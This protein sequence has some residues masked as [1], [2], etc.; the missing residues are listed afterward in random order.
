MASNT[1]LYLFASWSNASTAC[2]SDECGPPTLH[3]ACRFLQ[4]DTEVAGGGGGGGGGT[5]VE[6]E[7]VREAE[8][9]CDSLV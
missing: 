6:V 7:V 8:E 4:G 1:G 2:S 3:V 5:S 9:E